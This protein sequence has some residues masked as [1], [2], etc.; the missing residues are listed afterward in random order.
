M[1]RRY[2]IWFKYTI[3]CA[4][5]SIRLMPVYWFYRRTLSKCSVGF[6][7]THT[8][9]HEWKKKTRKRQKKREK[10]NKFS[11]CQ[12]EMHH[13]CAFHIGFWRHSDQTPLWTS[14]LIAYLFE[15]EKEIQTISSVRCCRRFFCCFF[16]FFQ[17]VTEWFV[18]EQ[19]KGIGAKIYEDFFLGSFFGILPIV[20]NRNISHVCLCDACVWVSVNE[21]YDADR[22]GE[23]RETDWVCEFRET[24]NW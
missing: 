13:F 10:R 23:Y 3:L 2:G 20:F 12:I 14:N 9:S 15:R 22:E 18:F 11:F 16:V 4:E 17:S 19:W 21:W 6:S 1:K 5:E 24:D 8:R 7:H